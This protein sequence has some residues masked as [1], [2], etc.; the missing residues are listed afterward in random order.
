MTSLQLKFF[1]CTS[2]CLMCACQSHGFVFQ[3]D[4]EQSGLHVGFT[5]E[6]PSK[7]DL[8][9]VVDNSGSMASKQQTLANAMDQMLATLALQGTS[10]RIGMVSTDAY[11]SV[12]DCQNNVNMAVASN[13]MSDPTLGA[14]GNCARPEVM[15]ARPHDG[16]LGRLIGA[17]DPQ[18]FDPANFAGLGSE[19]RAAINRLLPV[20]QG[21]TIIWPPT[22]GGVAGPRWV[23]D[24]DMMVADACRA[25]ACPAC[26]SGDACTTT[27]ADP[28]AQSL[29]KAYFRAN[30]SGLGN[31]G[32][33]W[34][35]GLKAALWAAGIDPQESTDASATSPSYNLLLPGAP[36]SISRL[37]AKQAQVSEPWLRPDAMLAVL[38]LSDEQDCSMPS[39]LMSL[40]GN[41]E[42]NSPAGSICY[43]AQAQAAFLDTSRMA[44][45][46]TA[47]KGHLASRV[48]VGFIGG[49]APLAGNSANGLLGQP[50]DCVVAAG[51]GAA[52][53]SHRCTCV[54][55]ADHGVNQDPDGCALTDLA[56]HPTDPQNPYAA[57]PACNAL[58][59]SRYVAFANN[60]SRRTFESIC[61][62]DRADDGSEMA[63]G[64]ALQNFARVATL[65]CFDLQ[66][67]RPV[68]GDGNN[69][70]VKR[71]SAASRQPPQALARRESGTQETGWFYNTEDNQ[72]CLTG[73]P[74]LIGDVYDIY[75]LDTS[76]L[77]YKR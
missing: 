66:E 55:S 49:V 7:V 4:A 25:C 47:A 18:A 36:N 34:E 33:G 40:R 63:F 58:A 75:V 23:I 19:A 1:F 30:L 65:P 74:R 67:L 43:Q 77:D 46:L 13:T 39:T 16:T 54:A 14:K 8:L 45:L 48:A 69:L 61:R 37:D 70:L 50:S 2:F 68:N 6:T 56:S 60:F 10:Y 38:F 26:N 15:L 44:K 57:L 27:C 72:V 9:F 71:A 21:N 22:V 29:I 5:V 12:R 62:N 31:S 59:G 41:Y 24:H 28:V 35:E 52:V 32:F 20:K 53:P 17:Y 51:A 73:M 3:P 11:G 42:V 76:A 64:P